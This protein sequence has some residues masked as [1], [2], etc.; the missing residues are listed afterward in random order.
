MDA[1]EVE[2]QFG[3]KNDV[4]VADQTDIFSEEYSWFRGQ[5]TADSTGLDGKGS[6]GEK[7]TDGTEVEFE[8]PSAFD[9]EKKEVDR[10]GTVEGPQEGKP[11]AKFQLGA[12]L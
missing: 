11:A 10:M 6:E 1:K 3:K 8:Q 4:P 9:G 12:S 2:Q 7:R 5:C